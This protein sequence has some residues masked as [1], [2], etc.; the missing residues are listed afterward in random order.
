M[1]RISSAFLVSVLLA[2]SCAKEAD[3]PPPPSKPVPELTRMQKTMLAETQDGT[4]NFDEAGLYA[5]LDA[6]R[7]CPRDAFGATVPVEVIETPA[8]GTAAKT[9]ELA[10]MKDPAAH[11]GEATLIEA[12]FVTAVEGVPNNPSGVL[13]RPDARW[14]STVTCWVLRMGR[15]F[16]RDP[17]VMVY[18]PSDGRPL[19][20]PRPGQKVKVAARFY[21][22]FTAETMVR[23]PK[24]HGQLVATGREEPYAAFVGGAAALGGAGG[25][26]DGEFSPGVKIALVIV[27]IAMGFGALWFIKSF[28]RSMR[29]NRSFKSPSQRWEER[30]EREKEEGDEDG[31]DDVELPQDPAEALKTLGGGDR[32]FKMKDEG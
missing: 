3:A 19:P 12:Q 13:A 14:G 24:N 29:E 18:F 28:T 5:L 15:S 22:I 6:A 27:L 20:V 4:R 17:Q 7:A 9:R 10:V 23:D 32:E 26:L 8:T 30:L 1:R 16:D 2:A 31:D 11:R 25:L 21:K